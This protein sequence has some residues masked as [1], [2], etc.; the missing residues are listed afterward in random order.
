MKTILAIGLSLLLS[1]TQYQVSFAVV[2]PTDDEIDSSFKKCR[3]QPTLVCSLQPTAGNNA[4]GTVLFTTT[5]SLRR[6]VG[7]RCR[8]SINADLND[9][10]PGKHGFHIHT[11]G[12]IRST[13]GN[14]LG[15]HFTNPEGTDIAHG[16]PN[17]A[18]RHWGDFGSIFAA[19]DG[20][21]SYSRKD[22]VITLAG[23]VGRGM[24][25][26]ESP[27]QGSSQQPTGASGARVASCVIG[28]ANPG[29]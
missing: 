26:H 3:S 24:I 18:I 2:F 21:A 15:G 1:A 13:D 27:D 10:K 4:T 11:Y 7:T 8:V 12:D 29:L 9:L 5:F 14:S 23:I 25:V 19:G 16:L 28:F 22:K 20:S 6:P 17:D